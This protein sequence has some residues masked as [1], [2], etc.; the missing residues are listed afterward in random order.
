MCMCMSVCVRLHVLVCAFERMDV[1][2][3]W[4]VVV[5]WGGVSHVQGYITTGG[6]SPKGYVVLHRKGVKTLIF[7]V[8]YLLNVP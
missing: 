2:F 3:F 6:V 8:I 4:V 5:G 7:S 1:A